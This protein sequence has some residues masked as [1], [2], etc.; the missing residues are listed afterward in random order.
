[1]W[2]CR[3]AR[4]ARRCGPGLR[5]TA[6]PAI[7]WV[8]ARSGTGPEVVGMVTVMCRCSSGGRR[9][10]M[11]IYG[12]LSCQQG[13]TTRYQARPEVR[14]ARGWSCPRGGG[15]VEILCPG[16]PSDGCCQP[17]CRTQ[18]V[19]ACCRPSE[20]TRLRCLPV[21]IATAPPAPRGALGPC[22]TIRVSRDRRLASPDPEPCR[23]TAPPAPSAPLPLASSFSGGW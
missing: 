21:W 11:V 23:S 14:G 1:M 20:T 7:A 8:A 18:R 16:V 3:H 6:A 19:A 13:H 22:C 2:A 9:G 12:T 10:H 5:V 17:A 4:R 15:S